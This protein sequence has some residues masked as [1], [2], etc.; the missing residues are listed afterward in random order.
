MG[1]CKVCIYRFC[2]SPAYFP[3]DYQDK[4][5]SQAGRRSSDKFLMVPGIDGDEDCYGL[6]NID[7]YIGSNNNSTVRRNFEKVKIFW[8]V[9]F[10]RTMTPASEV[11]INKIRVATPDSSKID[12]MKLCCWRWR[13]NWNKS[14]KCETKQ[15]TTQIDKTRC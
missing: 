15:R 14:I 8:N 10:S 2:L 11:D 9:K 1:A 12:C 4:Q 5:S 6:M 7:R 3:P 13:K